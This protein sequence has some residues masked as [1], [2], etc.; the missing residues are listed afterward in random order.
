MQIKQK[1]QLFLNDNAVSMLVP[2]GTSMFINWDALD[3]PTGVPQLPLGKKSQYPRGASGSW[4]QI[5]R[6]RSEPVRP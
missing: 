6:P 3:V 5:R 2:E 4:G 1:G